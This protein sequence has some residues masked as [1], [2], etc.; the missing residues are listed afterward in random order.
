MIEPRDELIDLPSGPLR[1]RVRGHG[2]AVVWC[3]GIFFPIEVDDHSALGRVLSDDALG[4]TVVRFDARGHGKSPAGPDATAH[5]WD[6]MARDVLELCDALGLEDVALGGISMGAAV[7]LHAAL[8]APARV[9]AMLLF[10]PPTAW[11]TRVTEQARYRTLLDF[12]TPERLAQHV[13]DDMRQLFPAGPIP[14]ALVAMVAALASSTWSALQ[15]VIE[16]AA[17]SDLPPKVALSCLDLPVLLRPWRDDPG[18]PL[19]TAQALASA[20]PA[21]DLKVLDSFD[22]EPGMRQAFARLR[23]LLV[24]PA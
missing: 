15:R 12:G 5:R 23:D 17:D 9:R 11:E 24:D 3:H 6:V 20:L 7:A 22:D 18:H 8:L 19:G 21:A 1:V 14:P 10:A 4:L 16:G 2:P 13:E